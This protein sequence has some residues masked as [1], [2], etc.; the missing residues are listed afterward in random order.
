MP[1]ALALMVWT[2]A[3]NPLGPVHAKAYGPLPPL[4][5]AVKVAG[6]VLAHTVA[7]FTL[8]AG[9]E[10]IVSCDMKLHS[11][12]LG[13]IRPDQA[14]RVSAGTPRKRAS[15]GLRASSRYCQRCEAFPVT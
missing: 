13:R 5:V 3:A 8:T 12:L 14:L 1:A 11:V 10:L 9:L 6:S 7:E 15:D 4:T 2:A